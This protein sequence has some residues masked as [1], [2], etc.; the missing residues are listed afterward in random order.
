MLD[1]Y[2]KSHF[3]SFILLKSLYVKLL[4]HFTPF[5]FL[6]TGQLFFQCPDFLQISANVRRQ[7]GKEMSQL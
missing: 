2:L 1:F 5:F 6:S 3:C 4:Y 7:I